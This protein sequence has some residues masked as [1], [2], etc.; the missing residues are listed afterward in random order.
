MRAKHNEK[1]C[2]ALVDWTAQIDEVIFVMELPIKRQRRKGS[3]GCKGSAKLDDQQ[4]QWVGVHWVEKWD[5]DTKSLGSWHS[6]AP[7][8]TMTL[9]LRHWVDT[10]TLEWRMTRLLKRSIR[11][12]FSR[13][14]VQQSIVY[15]TSQLHLSL[16]GTHYP[17]TW[18]RWA[19]KV[20]KW[21]LLQC[22]M[23]P[24]STKSC[25]KSSKLRPILILSGQ[26]QKYWS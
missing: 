22:T 3:L 25:L 16:S 18:P 23:L 2:L 8:H 14:E 12:L 11:F 15:I 6:P 13:M 4:Q 24:L 20:R 21:A 26:F 9:A 5:R 19:L 1:V 10:E 17:P 7:G